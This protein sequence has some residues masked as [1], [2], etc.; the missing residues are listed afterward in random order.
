MAQTILVGVFDILRAHHTAAIAM[1]AG[2]GPLTI[3]VLS[4]AT[5]PSR[6]LVNP[7]A[8][9]ADIVSAVRGVRAVFV[10]GPETGWALPD[11]DWLLVHTEVGRSIDDLA[12][13]WPGARVFPG[14]GTPLALA[15]R[16]IPVRRAA[17]VGVG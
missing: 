7:E 9:R 8:D 4:D 17:G 2:M 12:A 11:H 13:R 1:A 15:P 5:E 3:G 14:S 6:R 10:L 16:G